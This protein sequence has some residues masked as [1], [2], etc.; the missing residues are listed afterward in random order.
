MT[1]HSLARNVVAAL[2]LAAALAFGGGPALA[3]VK[4]FSDQCAAALTIAHRVVQRHEVSERLLASFE[5]F[6]L[7]NCDVETTFAQDTKA[8]VMALAEFKLRFEIW[9]TCTD[10]PLAPVCKSESRIQLERK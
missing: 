4:F 2:P 10:N 7:S 5:N 9:R 6:R 8:D 1:S 3:Q